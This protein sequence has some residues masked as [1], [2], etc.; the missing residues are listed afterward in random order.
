MA[1]S[2]DRGDSDY[3]LEKYFS[4]LG[5]NRLP[6]ATVESPSLE[7]CKRQL[8][9]AG[10]FDWMILKVSSNLGDFCSILLYSIVFRDDHQKCNI[11]FVTLAESITLSRTFGC[12]L[13]LFSQVTHTGSQNLNIL[14][15]SLDKK[16]HRCL[17]YSDV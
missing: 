13:S 9:L 6:R 8:D 5:W 17:C 14:P 1:F 7:V 4:L 15:A 2:W 16:N 11:H 10:W 3:I 12:F